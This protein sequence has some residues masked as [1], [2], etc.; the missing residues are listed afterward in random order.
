MA[1]VTYENK[2]IEIPDGS[3]IK[4]TCKE[5]GVPF[6]CQNGTCGT[7]IVEIIKGK[8]NL[9]PMNEKEKLLGLDETHRLSCQCKIKSGEIII[10]F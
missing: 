3:S 2:T 8:E 10:D 4:E 7:C 5:L 1:L 6:S 9:S